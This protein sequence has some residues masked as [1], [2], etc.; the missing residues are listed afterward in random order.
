MLASINETIE[1]PQCKSTTLTTIY[2]TKII[3]T[4]LGQKDYK[5][6]VNHYCKV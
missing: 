1:C 6:E 3:R 4:L 5:T 2:N